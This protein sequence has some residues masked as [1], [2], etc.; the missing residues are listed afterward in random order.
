M[1]IINHV[2]KYVF[3]YVLETIGIYSEKSSNRALN[4]H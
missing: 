2:S 3:V 1:K 4:L